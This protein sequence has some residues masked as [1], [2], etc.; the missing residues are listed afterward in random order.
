METSMHVDIDDYITF[1]KQKLTPKRL[2]HSLGVMQVISELAPIYDLDKTMAM[3]AGILHDIAKEFTPGEL[4]KQANE[5]NISFRTEYDKYPLF[6]HGPIGACYISQELGISNPIII[7]AI[8]RHSYFGDGIAQSTAF[9]W[10][11][12]FADMLEPSRDW[13]DLK[14]QLKPLVYAGKMGEGA[15]YLMQWIIPFH[16]S[17]SLPVHPNIRRLAHELL[18]LKNEKYLD[19]IIKLPV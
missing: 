6:L 7:D 5:N 13:D 16:E 1:A 15:C 4:I 12:H 8:S 10:C 3:V 11:L 14:S 18:T 17:A 9:C 19:E 2:K